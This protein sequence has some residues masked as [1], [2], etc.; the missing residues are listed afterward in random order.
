MESKTFEKTAEGH[1]AVNI[2]TENDIN[3]PI[4]GK[5]TKI[6]TYIQT[7][8]QTITD[9]EVLTDF[10]NVE[11]GKADEQLKK[12]D[13]NL[14]LLKDINHEVIDEKLI[15]T[16]SK[17]IE[18]GSKTFKASTVDLSKY[19]QKSNQKSTFL[20]NREHITLQR[21]NFVKEMKQIEDA[22]SK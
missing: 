10:L 6:G 22:M 2:V 1:L 17:A 12:I 21:D 3:L 18:K 5:L 15:Q 4:D 14:E 13:T 8:M 19:L 16:I 11:L 9:Y 20:K 7:T